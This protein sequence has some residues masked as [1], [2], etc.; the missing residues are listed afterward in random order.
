[1]SSL[2]EV[3]LKIGEQQ[4]ILERSEDHLSSISDK[5]ERFLSSS[6]S[7]QN[8][9][10]KTERSR[11]GTGAINQTSVAG[12]GRGG[13]RFGNLGGAAALGLG[14]LAA[15]AMRGLGGLALMGA[16]IPTFFGG[17][18]LGSEGM[19]YLQD[20][21]GM[22]F[23]GLKTAAL[24]FSDI[25]QALE[26]EAF[27]ALGAITA[28]SVVGG[29]KGAIGLGTMG[30]AISAF[31]TGLLAGDLIFSGV[32]ALGGDMQFDSMQKAVVGASTIF[33]GLDTKGMIALGG[34]LGAS[35]LA[36]AFGGGSKAAKG[37][38]FMGLGISGF[39]AGLLAGD[40]LFAGVNALGVDIDFSNVKTMLAGFSSAI[41]ELTLPAVTALGALMAGGALVGYSP[42]KAKSLAKG[43]FAISAGIVALMA[44]FTAVELIGAGSLALGASVDFSNVEKIMTG[45]SASI[46]SL[47]EKAVIALGSLLT[48]GG[49][50]GAITTGTGKANFVMGVSALAASIVAFMGAFA[51]GDV[52]ASAMGADGSSIKNV[53]A[54]FGEAINSLDDRAI[55]VLGTLIGVGGI[56]GA[57]TA[58]TG[59]AGALVFA[60]IPALGASIAGFF[61]AFDGL[62]KLGS[63]LGVNGSSTKELMENFSAGIKELVGTDMSNAAAVGTGLVSLS[64]GM[65]A[66]FGQQALGGV[67]NFF[68][69]IKGAIRDGWNYLFGKESEDLSPMASMV[70][71]LEPLKDLD[72]ALITKMDNFGIAINSFVRSFE[73]LKNIEVSSVTVSLSGLMADIGGVMSMMDA[74]LK[75]KPYD[76]GKGP[77]FRLFGNKRGIIDFGPGLNNL[78]DQ[79]LRTVATGIS[80]I[81]SAL[82]GTGLLAEGGGGGGGTTVINNY[83]N[84]QA[85]PAAPASTFG[86]LAPPP[87][88]NDVFS[89]VQ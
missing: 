72:D 81:R 58:M 76:T 89:S 54:N 61:L 78:D 60:G 64:T 2:T 56:L 15:G 85:A 80:N 33:N 48:A 74:M 75:G 22:D 39:L 41:G 9:E 63:V 52:A 34:L 13:S 24:G 1:M 14:G 67:V 23:E 32:T 47:D 46:G 79:D 7:L 18:L 83:Y 87:L 3:A 12:A 20:V 69:D 77:A 53:V 21:K 62:S 73:G 8:L 86:F 50:L 5:I 31:L 84:T 10:D 65:A 28:I 30:F 88:T 71:S 70:K 57:A 59:G 43:L 38:A 36:S 16:A 6:S 37:L 51:L 55:T 68:G 27:L 4:E 17:L 11:G 26:P 45:F 42:L 19:S 35:T 66:F 25:V 44:G 40:L 82:S 49:V 29:K